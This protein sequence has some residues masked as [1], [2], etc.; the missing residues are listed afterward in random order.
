MH[1]NTKITP[2]QKRRGWK[3]LDKTINA[4]GFNKA[5]NLHIHFSKIEYTLKGEVKH[6]TFDDTTYGPD[7]EPLAEVLQELKLEPTI[8]CESKDTMSEDALTMKKIYENIRRI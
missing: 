4:L 6:L 5:N 7:F 8:I 1:I 3:I 2:P